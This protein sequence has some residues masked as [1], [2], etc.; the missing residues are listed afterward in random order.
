M[1]RFSQRNDTETRRVKAKRTRDKEGYGKHVAIPS[2][3]LVRPKTDRQKKL[4]TSIN[5]NTLTFATGPAGTGK[6][7]ISIGE[8]LKQLQSE[9]IKKIILTK[10]FFEIDEKLGTLPGDEK[11]KTAV[12]ARPMADIF[13]RFISASHYDNLIKLGKIEFVP[14]GSILGCT[15]DDSFV[16]LDEAQNTTPSQMMVLLSR[17]GDNSKVVVCGD[18]KMQCFIKDRNGLEDAVFKLQYMSQVGHIEFE[19]QDIVRSDFCKQIIIAYRNTDD[20]D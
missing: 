11:E 5:V 18:Y 3:D 19:P 12:L 1:G 7:Y 15:F 4:I 14:L 13:K 2:S 8:A 17:V 10:P 16:I 20:D 6:T 9:K